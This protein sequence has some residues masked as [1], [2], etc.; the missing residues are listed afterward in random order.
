MLRIIALLLV[1][2]GGSALAAEGCAAQQTAC[3]T[4]CVLAYPGETQAAARTGCTTRCTLEFGRCQAND[5]VDQARQGLSE[6]TQQGKQF[7][8]GLL[9]RPTPPVQQ[10]AVP[11]PAPPANRGETQL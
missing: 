3:Q 4:Q 2:G 5:V 9:G 6:Q 10:P 11:P 8:D 7:L 1:L